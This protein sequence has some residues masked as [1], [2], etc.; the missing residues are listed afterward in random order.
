[1]AKW[2]N[3]EAT[4]DMSSVMC[5]SQDK[6]ISIKPIVSLPNVYSLILGHNFQEGHNNAW[7]CATR[8]VVIKQAGKDRK[9]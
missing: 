6:A 2:L 9:L 4:Y 7:D 5:Y 8:Y 3:G 1:M